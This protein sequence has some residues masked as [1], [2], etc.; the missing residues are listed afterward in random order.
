M[1][2]A[3]TRPLR[4]PP[5]HRQ[6]TDASKCHHLLPFRPFWIA[7]I[8]VVRHI[9]REVRLARLGNAAN[10]KFAYLDT[11]MRP[12]EMGCR[13]QHWRAIPTL[14]PVLPKIHT[15]ANATS[16][17]STIDSQHFRKMTSI[18]P[19]AA[20]CAET[21]ARKVNRRKIPVVFAY[22]VCG[23]RCPG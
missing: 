5:C 20:S 3:K 21:F 8:R 18:C 4:S 23:P 11:G 9:V 14:L 19:S 6:A 10:L 16:S 13:G 12:I 1:P 22:N 7:D 17:W 2:D 15:R